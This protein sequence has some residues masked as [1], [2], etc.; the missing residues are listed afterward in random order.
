MS[1][2]VLVESSARFSDCRRYRYTLTRRFADGPT[3]AFIGLNPSTADEHADDPTI[4]RCLGF[5]KRWGY[6]ELVMLNL[7]ALRSTDPPAAG[8]RF[9]A[10]HGANLARIKAEMAVDSAIR[11]RS[12]VRAREA[13]PKKRP[14]TPTCCNLGCFNER[15]PPAAFCDACVDAGA[16]QE[17]DE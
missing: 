1:G 17:D 5:A 16:T 12:A 15:V 10:E 2:M 13:M 7:Y 3:V 14:S 11:G 6:G 8:S 4:R 9:C